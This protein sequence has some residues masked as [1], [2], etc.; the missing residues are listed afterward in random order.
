MRLALIGSVSGLTVILADSWIFDSCC[1]GFSAE[2]S[3]SS[4]WADLRTGD[5]SN[6]RASAANRDRSTNVIPYYLC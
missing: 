4:L 2:R 6:A 5:K 1:G 3:I